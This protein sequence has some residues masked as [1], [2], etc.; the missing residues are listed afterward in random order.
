[1]TAKIKT[2]SRKT[3]HRHPQK[4]K[5][6]SHKAFRRVYWPYIPVVL[7]IGV[8]LAL[9]S[10]AG[11]LSAIIHQQGGRVLA[12]ATSMSSSGLLNSTNSA[13]ADNGAAALK[14]NN[15]LAA[16]AQAKAND[17][18]ARNYWSH[19]TPEGNPPWT[20]VTTQGYSYQKL[21]ENLAAGFS[22]EQS[23]VN[24]WMGSPPH[25]ENLLDSAFSDVGFGW[26]NN[27]NYTSAGG[28]PMTIV[29]AFYG[30][31]QVLAAQTNTAPA[32]PAPAPAKAVTPAP[33]PA[34]STKP[35]TPAPAVPAEPE[36][37]PATPPPNTES[38]I[39]PVE[40]AGASSRAQLALANLPIAQ[41]ATSLAVLGSF[42]AIGLW[43]S[44]HALAVRRAVAF[45]ETFA[46]RHPLLDIGLLVIAA[47]SFLLSQTAG[48][49]Q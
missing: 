30:K 39:N 35:A 43:A 28:G 1:M 37:K 8:L 15:K 32:P 31:P 26:A 29:V 3:G 24:G 34:G 42:A 20:F 38:D 2:A 25:R 5:G 10:Q 27:P 19:N 23:T 41:F 49:I 6:V 13:R 14:I 11:A 48:F 18:A 47:L 9:S 36:T 21:G 33:A 22:D 16:A 12:Y 40:L 4:P 46:I 17:M 45:G 7:I 44:R